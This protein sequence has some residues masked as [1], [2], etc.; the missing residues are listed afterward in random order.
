MSCKWSVKDSVLPF[1][2]ANLANL[3]NREKKQRLMGDVHFK[4][5]RPSCHQDLVLCKALTDSRI[6]TVK[7]SQHLLQRLDSAEQAD[8]TEGSEH[9]DAGQVEERRA[10]RCHRRQHHSGVQNVPTC[11]QKPRTHQLLTARNLT[12]PTW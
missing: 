8:D 6:R 5:V 1:Q 12:V 2:D 11:A 9:A 10:K 7:Q 3:R 4:L